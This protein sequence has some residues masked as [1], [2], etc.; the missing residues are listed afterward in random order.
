MDEEPDPE[1][2]L[3]ETLAGA[4]VSW[5]GLL[6][7]QL[8]ATAVALMVTGAAGTVVYG[9]LAALV[10]IEQ[11]LRFAMSGLV[12]TVQRTLPRYD[13]AERNTM[14]AGLY[15][16]TL[17]IAGLASGA[18]IVFD[19]TIIARTVLRPEDR[20]ALHL[21][22]PMLGVMGLTIASSNIFKAL[23]KIRTANLL[24]R[25]LLPVFRSLAIAA[26]LYGLGMTSL[27]PLW[28]ALTV[29]GL[30]AAAIGFG[31]VLDRTGLSTFRFGAGPELVA[32]IRSF[33]PSA[34]LT[35]AGVAVQM[36]SFF[37]LLAVFL[38]PLEAGAFSIALL[39]SYFIR[40]PLQSINQIFP[41]IAT[42]LYDRG[43]MEALDRMYEATSTLITA[44]IVPITAAIIVH[45]ARLLSIFSS[46]YSQFSTS[47]VLLSV[48]TLYASI[49]GSVG[50][51]LL[52]TDNQDISAKAQII[53]AAFSITASIVL[54]QRF[55]I[56]GLA[57][58][59]A[60][61]YIANN[62]VELGLLYHRERLF[63]FTRTDAE[64]LGLGVVLGLLLVPVS[65]APAGPAIAGT[66]VLAGAY[67]LL[68]YTAV[69]GD[70]ERTVVRQVLT[71]GR[72]Q[73]R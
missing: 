17:V 16:T 63:P 67:Y 72:P 34:M 10:R 18:I 70:L 9:I 62:T 40:W 36:F 4:S 20:T 2:L 21:L 22:G 58:G 27:I 1:A 8:G 26:V 30:L 38:P 31:L 48:T 59:Y 71:P 56:T 69:L 73:D 49:V 14:M 41:P 7:R 5:L 24:E 3:D 54:V 61:A 68:A 11:A 28:T 23:R 51:L 55:G 42:T 12:T 39:I 13:Q 37:I 19:E 52:M 43:D 25:F 33:L 35:S 46:S 57:I 65:H 32:D 66:I 50:L 44:A 45:A 6:V 53:L 47:L 60:L 29:A 64:L 15:S